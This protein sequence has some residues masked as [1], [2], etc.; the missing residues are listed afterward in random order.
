MYLIKSDGS[1]IYMRFDLAGGSG[2]DEKSKIK[3]T[4]TYYDPE[5]KENGD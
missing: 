5:L 1:R 3:S 2:T 4:L